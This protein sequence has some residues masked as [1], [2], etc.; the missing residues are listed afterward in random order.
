MYAP[1]ATVQTVPANAQLAGD[2]M[3]QYR[4]VGLPG[5]SALKEHL[6]RG[7]VCTETLYFCG[8]ETVDTATPTTEV[9][10]TG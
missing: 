7:G 6:V 8:K 9:Y 1:I 3:T 5:Y 2:K 10:S 4:A